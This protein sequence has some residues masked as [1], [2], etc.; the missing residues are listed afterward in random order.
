MFVALAGLKHNVITPDNTEFCEGKIEFGDRYYH[1]WKTNG[2]GNMNVE[3]AIKESCD[4]FFYEI[5]RKIG[6][7]KIAV[8]AK[9]F[10]LGQK[11]N[12]GFESEKQGIVPSKKW[13]KENYKENWY[14]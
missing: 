11:F 7:D 6:I 4:V 3:T 14:R 13:K 10:G 1:C 2:H 8:V 12:I 9:E 5:S